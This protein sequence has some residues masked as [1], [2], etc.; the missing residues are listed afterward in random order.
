MSSSSASTASYNHSLP[1][2]RKHEEVT[3]RLEEINTKLAEVRKRRLQFAKVKGGSPHKQKVQY[4][5]RTSKMHHP[6]LDFVLAEV[7]FSPYLTKPDEP[8]SRSVIKIPDK[9]RALKHKNIKLAELPKEEKLLDMKK[10]K[11]IFINEVFRYN[12]SFTNTVID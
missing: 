6:H 5:K 11:D 7:A 3:H 2:I 12:S 4:P 8:Y 9:L 1:S 10:V